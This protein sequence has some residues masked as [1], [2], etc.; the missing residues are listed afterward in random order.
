MP[1]FSVRADSVN[2]EEIMRQIRARVKEKRGADYT[3][4]EIKELAGVKL[5]RFLDPLAV[6]SG[7]LDEYRS[8]RAV[9]TLVDIEP[10]P[11]LYGFD[12]E[13]I[14]AS[15]RS[16]LRTLRKILN[17]IL[18]L[19]FNPN[20]L[21][22]VLNMQTALNGYYT[23]SIAR[24]SGR[25]ALNF[26]VLNNIVVELTRLSIENRNLKMRVESLNTRLDFAERRGR[27]LEGVV[28]YKQGA[29]PVSLTTLDPVADANL[30]PEDADKAGRRRRRRRGRRRGAAGEGGE[31]GASQDGGAEYAPGDDAPQDGDDTRPSSAGDGGAD[32]AQS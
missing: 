11:D 16:F 19:F 5:E 7:L 21:I 28:Q 15:S 30:A 8:Q 6:R 23:R 9:T 32:P 20:P 3:E 25:E 1:E 22:R 27:A 18:K 31:A 24:V 14:Y 26:E 13:S 10:A 4:E 17:P 12:D 2:V 29:S